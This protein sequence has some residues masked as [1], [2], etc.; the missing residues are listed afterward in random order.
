LL[1]RWFE[2]MDGSHPEDVLDLIADDFQFSVVF[3][4]GDATTSGDFSGGRAAM[5]GY[6]QQR[7]KGTRVHR[8]L[9]ASTVGDTELVLGEVVRVDTGRFEASFLAS[10]QL[11]DA[12]RVRRMLMG[13]SPGVAFSS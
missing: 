6:L 10:V 13:R 8:L 12:G 4:T 5:Q 11:D 2:I 9:S 1:A 7:E 3:S